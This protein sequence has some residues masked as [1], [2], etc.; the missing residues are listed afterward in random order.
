[1]GRLPLASTA[2]P[3]VLDRHRPTLD[4]ATARWPRP[5]RIGLLVAAALVVL[6]LFLISLSPDTRGEPVIREGSPSFN[7]ARTPDLLPA[8]PAFD[9]WL[10]FARVREDGLFVQSFAVAPLAI[11]AYRGEVSGILPIAAE[12][13]I[14]QLRR[15]HA[16][17]E[18]V[19]EGKTRV[20]E[21]PAYAVAFNARDGERRIFGKSVLL[22]EPEPGARRGVRLDMLTTYAGGVSRATDVGIDGAIKQPFRTF[23]FG[24]E[25]P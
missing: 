3:L 4:E 12:A 15:R 5:V 7:F 25:A 20:N 1:M 13:T 8:E 16:G 6:A 14:E 2:V 21:V 17:F 18:L 9:Q 24:T 22:A 11:P 23:R 10:R 19:Q